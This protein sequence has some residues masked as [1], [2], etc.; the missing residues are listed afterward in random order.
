MES[1]PIIVLPIQN[2]VADNPE[3]VQFVRVAPDLPKEKV[4][5]ELFVA[6][7]FA[8]VLRQRFPDRIWTQLR[9]V[10]PGR[11]PPDVE[12]LENGHQFGVEIGEIKFGERAAGN[13]RL[14]EFRAVL[15]ESLRSVRPEFKDAIFQIAFE[16][17][18]LARQPL[19]KGKQ[20]RRLAEVVVGSLEKAISQ[21]VLLESPLTAIRKVGTPGVSDPRRTHPD[22]PVILLEADAIAMSP[23]VA[24]QV[25]SRLA[26]KKVQTSTAGRSYLLL[27]SY[28]AGF[29]LLFPVSCKAIDAILRAAPAIPYDEVFLFDMHYV[30]PKAMGFVVNPERRAR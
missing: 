6:H 25:V 28:G 22:D 21:S 29:S 23:A 1:P 3:A 18:L 10:E 26:S 9:S 7:A 30:D 24:D 15:A 8:G 27:W 14:A 4:A 19:P 12:G 16:D 11:D 17:P 13:D 2:F 5:R 20:L